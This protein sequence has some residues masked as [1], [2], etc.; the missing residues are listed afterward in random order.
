MKFDKTL[1]YTW[2]ACYYEKGVQIYHYVELDDEHQPTEDREE[3]WSYEFLNPFVDCANEPDEKWISK[4][5][6]SFKEARMEGVEQLEDLVYALENLKNTEL[7]NE[8]GRIK[9]RLKY[10]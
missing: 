2:G 7:R 3:F 10:V 1:E 9:K 4:R 8:I 5:F 6:D